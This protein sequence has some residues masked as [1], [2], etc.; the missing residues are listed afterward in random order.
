MNDIEK[1]V[2]TKGVNEWRM[3]KG[4]GT[5]IIPSPANPISPLLEILP[6]LF[7]RSPT[8]SVIIVIN[9]FKDREEVLNGLTHSDNEVYNN[10][11][12][13]LISKGK[14]KALTVDFIADNINHLYPTLT[15][16]Y[17]PLS[18]TFAHLG[19]LDKS[20]FK[21]FILTNM[22]SSDTMSDI[23]N[24]CPLISEFKQ[25]EL[26][27]LRVTR[28][29]EEIRIPIVLEDDTKS[30]KLLDYYN[31]EINTSI[32]IFGSLEN[33]NIA[34]TG[35]KTTNLSAME[36]CVTLAQNNGWKYDLDMSLD[37]NRNI[38][39][40]YNPNA[41]HE[42]AQKVYDIIRER[43]NL[44]ASSEDKLSS[45]LEIVNNHKDSKILIINKYPDF[46][47]KVTE[48]LNNNSDSNICM[49]YHNK[50]ENIEAVDI[51]GDPI[52]IKSGKNKGERKM[53]GATSQKKLAQQ[54]FN[55]GKINIL[56]TNNL[57][58]KDLSID[59]DTIICTSSL[60]EDMSTYLYRL[61]K[62][63]FANKIQLYTIYIKNSMEEKAFEKKTL[64]KNHVIVNSSEINVI[65]DENLDV[66]VVD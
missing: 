43:S 13:D 54:M 38:D 8:I 5:F 56:S 26:N 20:R 12:K 58:D 9:D 7:N 17:K 21:M 49:N 6:K 40:I 47:S 65:D 18:F 35:D 48:Y 57:P 63:N 50:L 1:Q 25:N 37:Y 19:V 41:L 45:I 11:Y 44:L 33:V 42:R 15:I 61:T 55:I 30:K 64:S 31:K 53:M 27:L 46:A 52:Y 16:I 34:R 14:I 60:C 4:V 51:Y 24:I 10:V 28:P 36:F 2:M 23:Y 66:I 62:V 39:E 59:V 32:S 29:V 3:N 22:L